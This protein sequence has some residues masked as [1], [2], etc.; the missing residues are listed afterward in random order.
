MVFSVFMEN[1][2]FKVLLLLGKRPEF[3]M[4]LLFAAFKG[5]LVGALSFEIKCPW[6]D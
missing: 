5:K 4:N 3:T 1:W 2:Q 6:L